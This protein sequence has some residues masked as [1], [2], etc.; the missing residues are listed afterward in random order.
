MKMKFWIALA[1]AAGTMGLSGCAP[2]LIAGGAAAVVVV[3]EA[4]EKD[5]DDG[6]F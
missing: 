1:L 3:D 6:I 4:A 5:G 2:A